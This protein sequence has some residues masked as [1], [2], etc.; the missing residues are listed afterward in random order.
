VSGRPRR[1]LASNSAAMR[2]AL[3]GR[4][5]TSTGWPRVSDSFCAAMRARMSLAPPGTKPTSMRS[6]RCGKA[7]ACAPP[8]I[9][10]CRK[11]TTMNRTIPIAG[12]SHP[13]SRHTMRLRPCA[14]ATNGT[15]EVTAAKRG[16]S[17]LERFLASMRTVPSAARTKKPPKNTSA[18]RSPR[19]MMC[20]AAQSMMPHMI[21][22]RVMRMI[23]R[24]GSSL[25]K[26]LSA[27]TMV[28]LR[29]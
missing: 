25:F 9:Q 22:C 23:P 17:G 20:A 24:A 11:T 10:G 21:G 16:Q 1:D 27:P 7:C 19:A 14:M 12:R 28:G 29:E 3:P 5:S 13:I 15:C 4:F 2:P 6:G 18:L 8:E 26:S